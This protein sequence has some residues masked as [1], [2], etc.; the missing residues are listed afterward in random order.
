MI[1]NTPQILVYNCKIMYY[2][3][4]VIFLDELKIMYSKGYV[5]K[6]II[7]SC[8]FLGIGLW[9]LI[10]YRLQYYDFITLALLF[11]GSIIFFPTIK[12]IFKR[13]I[14]A[15]I[16]ENFILFDSGKKY[17]MKD[18]SDVYIAG[19]EV[20]S[21][22]YFN[23]FMGTRIFVADS[24]DFEDT[25]ENNRQRIELMMGSVNAETGVIDNDVLIKYS[26]STLFVRLITAW[27]GTSFVI[28]MLLDV[29]YFNPMLYKL[30]IASL[31]FYII[32]IYL[33][34]GRNG[35]IYAKLTNSEII[36]R[37]GNIVKLSNVKDYYIKR[38]RVKPSRT[39]PGASSAG[40]ISRQSYKERN[41]VEKYLI[42]KMKDGS[43]FKFMSGTTY[44]ISIE[45]AYNILDFKKRKYNM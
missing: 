32:S 31:F 10:T 15:T 21:R 8:T 24:K 6:N 14:R 28:L 22:L 38:V 29:D 44:D 9:L 39:S 45:Q 18:I 17:Y 42:V 13:R 27:I 11:F 37:N 23:T 7:L 26:K 30:S 20:P 35:R 19:N 41:R 36:F 33:L 2:L 43:E 16:N 34:W 40:E 3:F 4:G 5:R 25:L 1:I 12:V